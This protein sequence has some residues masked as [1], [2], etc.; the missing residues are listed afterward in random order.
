M[1]TQVLVVSPLS[2]V[3][4]WESEFKKFAP[5]IPTCVYHGTPEERKHLVKSRMRNPSTIPPSKSAKGNKKGRNVNTTSNDS[6]LSPEQF[7]VVLTTFEMII[8][9]RNVLNKYNWCFVIVD[10]GHRLKNMNSKLV[11][12][13]KCDSSAYQ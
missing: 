2:V 13:T 7:P 10:E 1:V 12:M 6:D 3:H 5:T 11:Q 9:D 8:K 4:N